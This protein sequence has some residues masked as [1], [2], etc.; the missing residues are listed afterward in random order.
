MDNK[1]F[2]PAAKSQND[3]VV[4]DLN[5]FVT[6]LL[7]FDHY[8]LDSI[9]MRDLAQMVGVFGVEGLRDLLST[10]IISIHSSPLT[11]GQIETKLENEEYG[12]PVKSNHEEFLPYN[13]FDPVHVDISDRRDYIGHGLREINKLGFPGKRTAGLKA[14]ILDKLTELPNLYGDI[15]LMHE[16]L[17]L[18]G[19]V[20]RTGIINA[21]TERSHKI[22]EALESNLEFQFSVGEDN[23]I[24]ASTN[25]QS[26][27]G[28]GEYEEHKILERTVLAIGGFYQR[29]GL[30]K[31]YDSIAWFSDNDS[32]LFEAEMQRIATDI[33]SNTQE[34]RM[35]RVLEL[36]GLPSL[37]ED[38][39][40]DVNRIMKMRDSSECRDFR[41]WLKTN[42]AK[43]DADIHREITSF[44]TAFANSFGTAQSRVARFAL[45][46][47]VANTNP[48][49]GLVLGI[50]DQFVVDRVLKR[51]GPIWFLNNELPKL[52][53]PF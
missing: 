15:V 5:G 31:G 46:T 7:L 12:R 52:G 21:A 40:L 11:I 49:L 50:M 14:E 18:G 30:M 3:R 10:G 53:R 48:P 20:A 45:S 22:P 38:S 32:L 27:L 24:S 4:L 2:A 26:L 41:E 19:G 17:N 28:I 25:L 23:V 42:D 29:L 36:R 37:T 8:T 51:N 6:R 35:S 13:H 47:V 33:R 43:S 44:Y 34:A 16:A 1:I 39:I 9:L